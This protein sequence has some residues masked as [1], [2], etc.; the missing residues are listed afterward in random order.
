MDIAEEV[1]SGC[2]QSKGY[3][4]ISGQRIGVKEID[5]LAIKLDSKGNISERVHVEVQVSANP[6]GVLR[7]TAGLGKSGYN[8]KKS[9]KAYIDKKFLHDLIRKATK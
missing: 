1:V 5:L 4:V 9:A 6:V 8:P 3:F 7:D 2:Y